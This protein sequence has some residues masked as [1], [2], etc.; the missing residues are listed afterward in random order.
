M[1]SKIA[2]GKH[3]KNGGSCT[4]AYGSAANSRAPSV[5]QANNR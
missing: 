5:S 4:A 2:V 3:E 1:L